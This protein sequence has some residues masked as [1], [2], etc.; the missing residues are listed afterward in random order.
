M[1]DASTLHSAILAG[2]Y[3][4]VRRLLQQGA[5]VNAPDDGHIPLHVAV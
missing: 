5:D 3:E 2:H 4:E 1:S